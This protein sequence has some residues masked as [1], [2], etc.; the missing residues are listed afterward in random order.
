M[1]IYYIAMCFTKK[2]IVAGRKQPLTSVSRKQLILN[3]KN[4]KAD[5]LNFK[6]LEKIDKEFLRKC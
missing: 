4:L 2:I 5:N 1:E 3:C 6:T